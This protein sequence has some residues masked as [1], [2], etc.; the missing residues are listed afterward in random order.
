MPKSSRRELVD[1]F[2]MAARQPLHW[3]AALRALSRHVGD[4]AIGLVLSYPDSGRPPFGAAAHFDE[5]LMLLWG[6][7]YFMQDPWSASG[8]FIPAGEAAFCPASRQEVERMP[9]YQEWMKPQGF[10]PMAMFAATLRG[11]SRAESQTLGFYSRVEGRLLSEGDREF[12]AS[13]LPTIQ[14][15]TD[16]SSAVL[17]LSDGMTSFEQ[18]LHDLRVPVL[19]LDDDQ[20]VVW[21]NQEMAGLLERDERLSVHHGLFAL[22]SDDDT[23]RFKASIAELAEEGIA[24]GRREV[25]VGGSQ[26][27]QLMLV[28]ILDAGRNARGFR[29]LVTCSTEVENREETANALCDRYGLLPSEARLAL[30]M[31]QGLSTG[32]AAKRLS[33]TK[34]TVRQY[35]KRVFRKT[36]TKG[37]ADLVRLVVRDL[38]M[39]PRDDRRS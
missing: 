13:L 2:E 9:F 36:G 18:T 12:V 7:K 21:S 22:G 8:L 28:T 14:E 30:L 39:A 37:Q 25:L 6:Q 3:T 29:F 16:V 32:E 10:L 24:G 4:A 35:L 26:R 20:R 38:S 23:E 11:N 5:S 17:G 31:A 1:H 33:L 15:A 34:G 19:H 27:A